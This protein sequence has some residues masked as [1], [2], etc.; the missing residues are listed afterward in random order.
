ML[1]PKSEYEVLYNIPASH[2]L[3]F[4]FAFLSL[5]PDVI[6]RILLFLSPDDLSIL[7]REV[8]DLKGIDTDVYLRT[9]WFRHANILFKS[10]TQGKTAKPQRPYQSL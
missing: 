1:P 3:R 4:P 10:N 5:P 9:I 8:P 6:L 2:P 7:S